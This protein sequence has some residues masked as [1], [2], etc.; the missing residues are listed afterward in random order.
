[1][2]GGG[3]KRK[4]EEEHVVKKNGRDGNRTLIVNAEDAMIFNL[5]RK[6]GTI[7]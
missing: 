6:S 2:A 3:H 7:K 4:A 5:Q 1:M